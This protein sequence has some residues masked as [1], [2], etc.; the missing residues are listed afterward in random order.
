MAANIWN[1]HGVDDEESQT[2]LSKI[3]P[4]PSTP[5]Q[6]LF[7]LNLKF[8]IFSFLSFYPEKIWG[9]FLVSY[10]LFGRTQQLTADL[11]K[12]K[13]TPLTSSQML[14]LNELFSLDVST[15]PGLAN[16]SFFF[17]LITV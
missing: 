10:I 2:S 13:Q 7:F 8:N 1:V 12:K 15:Y 4:V 17:L 5:V 9:Y 14:G 3:Q 11:D 16:F 6:V